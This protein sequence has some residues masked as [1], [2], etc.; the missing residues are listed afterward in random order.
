[1]QLKKDEKQYID[2][3]NDVKEKLAEASELYQFH[4]DKLDETS[5]Q[6]Q[7]QGGKLNHY[8]IPSV[9]NKA[10]Y[11][12]YSISPVSELEVS[13]FETNYNITLPTNFRTFLIV[14]G[15]PTASPE[16][17]IYSMDKLAS[18]ILDISKLTIPCPLENRKGIG[19]SSDHDD[20]EVSE[21]EYLFN[22]KDIHEGTIEIDTGGNPSTFHLIIT[23]NNCG[24]VFWYTEDM[25]YYLG[26]F[27]DWYLKWLDE[28]LDT[29]RSLKL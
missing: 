23:G 14:C 3:W 6:L 2:L 13:I 26:K 1:M 10:R 17:G 27:E 9:F 18:R 28:T 19:F 25:M 15:A 22:P 7:R 5:I 12:K 8:A 29:L 20:Q 11:H 16:Y 24:D 21:N 4:K